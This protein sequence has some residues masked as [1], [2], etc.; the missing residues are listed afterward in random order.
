MFLVLTVKRIEPLSSNAERV[1]D[2]DANPTSTDIEAENSGR[3]LV[4]FRRHEGI[5]EGFRLSASADLCLIGPR[6]TDWSTRVSEARRRE[7]EG[8]NRKPRAA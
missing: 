8:E 1:G 3:V 4:V 5:I 7:P 6:I 2:C